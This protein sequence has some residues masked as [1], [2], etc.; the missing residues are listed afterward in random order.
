MLVETFVDTVHGRCPEV[1]LLARRELSRVVGRQAAWSRRECC[2]TAED[3]NE[4][5]RSR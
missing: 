3:A 5:K 2:G 1:P 4:S